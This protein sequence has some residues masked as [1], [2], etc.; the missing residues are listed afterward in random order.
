[1]YGAYTLI[2]VQ[3]QLIR[4]LKSYLII[5]I[6]TRSAIYDD[7]SPDVDGMVHK[8][9]A[10]LMTLETCLVLAESVKLHICH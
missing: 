9:D 1:M 5:V 3:I 7:T 10:G 4:D 2:F 6:F 8:I